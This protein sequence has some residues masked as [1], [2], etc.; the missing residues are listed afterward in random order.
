MLGDFMGTISHKYLVGLLGFSLVL[1]GCAA[2]QSVIQYR[3]ISNDEAFSFIE[4]HVSLNPLPPYHEPHF[5]QP[6]NKSV[7]CKI[8][9][10]W[11]EQEISVG[12]SYWS[13]ECKSGFAHGLGAYIYLSDS[14]HNQAILKISEAGR[15]NN[16]PRSNL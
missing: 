13:G 8:Q 5:I 16:T 15:I 6:A 7:S 2:S 11:K 9:A 3:E 4:Q 14:Y 10:M 12:K 1:T